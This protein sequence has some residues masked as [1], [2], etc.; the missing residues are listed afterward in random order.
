MDHDTASKILSTCNNVTNYFKA[1]HIGHNL[2]SDSAKNLKIEGGGLKCFIKTRWTF[3]YET[4]YS[5]VKI[6]RALDEVIFNLIFFLK[7]IL[8]LIKY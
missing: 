6:R 4:T 5:I 7:R 8:Y 1:S 2:L 3:I